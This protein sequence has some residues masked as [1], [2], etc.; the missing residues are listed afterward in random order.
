MKIWLYY[1]FAFFGIILTRY[2]LIAGGAYL[3]FYSSPK[4]SLIK[5]PLKIKSPSLKLIKQD[6]ALSVMATLALS[7]C[8]A[9]VM[10]I[11]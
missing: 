10:T 6:I 5:Q 7:I 9:L 4:Q 1:L 11:Y 3:L 8:A 2:F